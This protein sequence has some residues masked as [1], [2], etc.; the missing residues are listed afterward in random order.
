MIGW[1][2]ASQ[3]IQNIQADRVPEEQR[4]RIRGPGPDVEP[5]QIAPADPVFAHPPTTAPCRHP[6]A[7]M[8][9]V[10][11]DLRRTGAARAGDRDFNRLRQ[12][13][14]ANSAVTP[15]MSTPTARPVNASP[16]PVTGQ[17]FGLTITRL[18]VRP[19]FGWNWL[20]RSAT[21]MRP[22][23]P[24]PPSARRLRPS[25]RPDRSSE[26]DRFVAKIG[27][28]GIAAG[29]LGAV[30]VY[31]DREVLAEN[32]EAMVRWVE[33]ALR[34]ARTA[35]HESRIERSAEPLPHER[36]L[37]DGSFHWGEPTEP[38]KKATDGTRID[39]VQTDPI[40]WFMADKGE[41]GTAFLYR[42]TSTL[43]DVARVLGR[44]EDA[45]RYTETAERV[46]EAWRTEFLTA[47]GRTRGD[48]QAAYVRA[49]SL[50]L[51]PDE[52]RAAAAARL[53]ELIRAAGTHLG[54]GF[55]S[56]GNLLPV[57]ADTGH[58]DIAYELLSRRGA[59]SWLYML[60]RGA[61]TIWEDWEGVDENGDAHDSLN[62][63]RKGA[64]IRFLHTHTLGLRQSPGSVA[65]ESFEVARSPPVAEVGP[66][67]ARVPAGHDRR[68]VASDRR[69]ADH[70]RGRAACDYRTGRLPRRHHR[71][72]HRGHLP[73]HP[74]YGVRVLRPPWSVRSIP[75][76]A[77]RTRGQTTST[78]SAFASDDVPQTL[79]VDLADLRQ[80]QPVHEQQIF[81][82]FVAGH[83]HRGECGADR[84]E[85]QVGTRFDDHG[86]AHPLP[87]VRVG[88]GDGG[89]AGEHRAAGQR[90][91][92]PPPRRSSR[93]P[94]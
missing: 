22:V 16:G 74:P 61:T 69:R 34:T 27:A 73:C 58:A 44:I 82:Q 12:A 32:W 2:T 41:V 40:A 59:P 85:G 17:L 77:H 20:G 78:G 33:W 19:D 70:H 10:H 89:D 5:R 23:R 52:L 81:G 49:L 62:H 51:V 37:W 63:Y 94:D 1:S 55:L 53:V 25:A 92:R 60:D 76:F 87:Q 26:V 11:P 65:W 4:G 64:V 6:R 15:S 72:R 88:L 30:P 57:L 75:S 84:F 43:A 47:D 24:T 13:G 93:R 46:R 68:R 56:T 18:Y 67:H 39:P 66:G 7:A 50:G 48:T 29:G 8:F 36:Y 31:G 79:L 35:H 86:H 90:G 14:R 9:V 54:T 3:A 91:S 80:R 38:K 45:S 42:S 21:I 83:L 71:D 28:N